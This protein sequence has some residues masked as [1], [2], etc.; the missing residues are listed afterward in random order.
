[1]NEI[2]KLQEQVTF[3]EN[4]IEQLN[5]ALAIQQQQLS[6]LKKELRL[7]MKLIQQRRTKSQSDESD[8]V[9]TIVHEIPPH[10]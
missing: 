9:N 1:M 10:Y 8:A 5:N 7:V 6:Q 2:K 3:Q 4:T